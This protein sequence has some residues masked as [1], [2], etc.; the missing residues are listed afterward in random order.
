MPES[1]VVGL[2]YVVTYGLVLWYAGRLYRR[3]RRLRHRD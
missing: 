3:A 1:A 2:A